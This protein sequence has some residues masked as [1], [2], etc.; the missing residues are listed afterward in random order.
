M[1]IYHLLVLGHK[2]EGDIYRPTYSYIYFGL[3]HCG[4][5]KTYS[6]YSICSENIDFLFI[7]NCRDL[8][9]IKILNIMYTD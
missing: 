2:T 1:H 8:L 7:I 3:G 5:S 9:K 6:L 4:E